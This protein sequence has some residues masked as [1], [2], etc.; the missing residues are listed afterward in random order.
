MLKNNLSTNYELPDTLTSPNS[1][2]SD[3]LT[4]QGIRTQTTEPLP[5]RPPAK[6][7]EHGLPPP[8]PEVAVTPASD[9]S[10]EMRFLHRKGVPV[11][12]THMIH[13][14]ERVHRFFSFLAGY[15]Q[16]NG[17]RV[18]VPELIENLISEH[19]LEYEETIER[20]Q[21]EF[22]RRNLKAF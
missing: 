2:L 3:W 7:G 1:D 6:T 8:H 22:S 9:V 10:Y 16:V 15:T 21:Q 18:S 17:A 14:S 20:L 19:L 13:V 5:V 11:R 4:S 12:P